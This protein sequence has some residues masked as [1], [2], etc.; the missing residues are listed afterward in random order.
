MKCNLDKLVTVLQKIPIEDWRFSKTEQS[1]PVFEYYLPESGSIRILYCDIFRCDRIT[2]IEVRLL[3]DAYKKIIDS[4]E[5][6]IE[7]RTMFERKLSIFKESD[8]IEFGL[9]SSL[10]QRLEKEAVELEG[11]RREYEAEI[12]EQG[13]NKWIQELS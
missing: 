7:Q 1:L 9:F 4:R 12:F 2:T 11:K 10:I 13:Y 5:D 8:R 3:R 6:D